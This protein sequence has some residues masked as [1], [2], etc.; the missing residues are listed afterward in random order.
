MMRETGAM[1][2]R[3]T[4]VSRRFNEVPALA[5]A[6]LEV[7]AGEIVSLFGPS[8][9][10]KTTLLRVTAGLERADEGTVGLDGEILSGP[11]VFTPPQKRSMGLVFQ[12]YVLFPHLTAL[13]NVAFGL[14]E[15]PPEERRRRAA[16]ELSACGLDG[17]FDRHPH[18]L[19]G[20]QQQRTAL[21]RALARRPKVMLLDE[22]FAAVDARARDALRRE[23]RRILKSAGAASIL[24][25]HDADEAL[26]LGDRIAIMKEGRIIETAR[27]EDLFLR[28]LTPEGALLFAGAQ[29]LAATARNG[30]IETA[31]G[32]L[33]AADV[34][35]GAATLVLLP[36]AVGFEETPDAD[37]VVAD[38]RFAG[39]GWRIEAAA[40]PTRIAGDSPRPIATGAAVKA[41]FDSSLARVFKT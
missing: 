41:I 35:E 38:C 30:R 18:Q 25:T 36:G 33:E 10:G 7:G 2:L 27:P 24:V 37:L 16:E 1:A 9:C 32:V 11:G 4:N 14:A 17:L 40:G 29:S 31:V 21:A 13:E 39:P 12:D 20:G 15:L 8:G 19:S 34:A 26:A 5:G 28:P 22:P 23:V 3:L 6:A